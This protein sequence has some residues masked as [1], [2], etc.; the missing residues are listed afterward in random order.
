LSA[1]TANARTQFDELKVELVA[2]V[3]ASLTQTF[4]VIALRIRPL[5][6]RF[7][8]VS[9]LLGAT[10]ADA[11]SV[12]R[13]NHAAANVGANPALFLAASASTNTVFE[14]KFNFHLWLFFASKE[15][16]Q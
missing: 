16:D 1:F 11:R 5:L 6:H 13:S 15:A 12:L 3:C 4:A 9:A 2:F 7:D 8:A 10:Q 14:G